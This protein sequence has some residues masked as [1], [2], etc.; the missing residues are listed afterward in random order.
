MENLD[1][2]ARYIVAD[3]AARAVVVLG[4]ELTREAA[5]RHVASGAAA[6][7]M[8]RAGIAGL[9]LATLTKDDER[10]TLQILG[11]GP[12][13][14][15]TVDASGAGTARM[16]VGNPGVKTFAGDRAR[17][18]LGGV[19]GHTGVVSVARDL[20][21]REPFRG[22]TTIVDGEID[23]DVEH[24]LLNSE[25]IDSALACEVLPDPRG[26]VLFAAGILVQALPNG[27]GTE[28]VEAAR[29]RMRAG[30]IAQN[31]ARLIATDGDLSTGD[32]ERALETVTRAALGPDA[33]VLNRLDTRPIR[34][35]CPCSPQRAAATLSLLGDKD[36]AALIRE[37][38]ETSVTCEFCRSRYDF[39]G[40]SLDEIRRGESRP[41]VPPN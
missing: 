9:L 19:V 33:D 25:Q 3:G 31:L 27:A 15:L 21:L 39:T 38:G 32:A 40:Q 8:G 13:G 18:R 24:Y 16:F 23:T 7:A 37:E 36:L 29:G 28:L 1:L 35:F 14:A 22:Q 12:L 20:G 41:T 2:I 4:T 10:V 11:N 6:L 34:F 26:D 30:N 5:R 17:P